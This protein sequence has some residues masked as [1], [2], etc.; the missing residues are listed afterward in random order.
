MLNCRLHR[1]FG[2]DESPNRCPS[3]ECWAGVSFTVAGRGATRTEG[4]GSWR[5]G[6]LSVRSEGKVH[7]T[8]SVIVYD[9][10]KN[11]WKSL[12]PMPTA[13]ERLSLVAAGGYLYAIGG[14]NQIGASLTTVERYDPRTN[15]WRTMNPMVQSRTLACAV[16]TKVGQRRVL[17]V[18]AGAE[19]SA[20]GTLV[21]P[22][23][24]TEVLDLE[25]GQW[26]LLNIKL[27]PRRAAHG[28]ATSA[29]GRVLT[30]GGVI[31]DE[32][33]NFSAI[34][35]VDTLSLKPHDLP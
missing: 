29:G 15:K 12:A 11:I 7:V 22:R 28:C 24:T 10:K 32:D 26:T 14:D 27:H 20:D 17:V 30:V 3:A 23:D 9:P 4:R 18:V 5:T 34:P 16:G 6:R 2:R 21:G 19:Y 13:R 31:R 33:G 35:D 8:D 25:T 1:G